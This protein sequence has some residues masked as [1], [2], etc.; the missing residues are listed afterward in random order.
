MDIESPQTAWVWDCLLRRMIVCIPLP[1]PQG[2]SICPLLLSQS[3]TLGSHVK[4][5]GNI[6]TLSAKLS[7]T[8]NT[9]H[10]EMLLPPITE[11]F[12]DVLYPRPRDM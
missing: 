2:I 3:S 6:W 1:F 11:A 5:H 8:S 12:L 7:F 4:I 9:F 10:P